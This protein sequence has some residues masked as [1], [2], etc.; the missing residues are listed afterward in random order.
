MSAN[1]QQL[2][3]LKALGTA[4]VHEAQGQKGALDSGLKPLDP[5]LRMA[6][7]AVTVD[8][9]PS[10]NL[11]IHYALTKA[12]P[13]DVLVVDAKGFLEAGPWG[14]VLTLAALELGL[15]GLVVNGSVRDGNAII[16]MGFPVFC[17][18]LSIKGTGKNQPGKVNVPVHF[19]G[20]QINPGDIIVGD[21]DGLVVVS[22]IEVDSVIDKSVERE[23]KEEGMRV[24][25]KEGKTMVELLNLSETLHRFG[26]Q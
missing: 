7:P 10:D 11:M 24:A 21:R 23:H 4:T 6:G 16:E 13:G 3:R 26:L 15:A 17:R 12:K 20:V 2:E 1:K 14:D 18:G 22:P 8:I 19:G 25:L 9:R 5:T